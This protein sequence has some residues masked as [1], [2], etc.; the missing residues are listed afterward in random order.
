M[1]KVAYNIWHVKVLDSFGMPRTVFL[2]ETIEV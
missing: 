2:E 1:W